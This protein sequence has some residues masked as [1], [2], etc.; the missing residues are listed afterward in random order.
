MKN[1]T[2]YLELTEDKV[3]PYAILSGDPRRVEKIITLLDDVVETSVSREYHTYRGTYKGM[4]VTVSSTGIGGPSAAI[5]LEELYEAGVE[6]AV[7]LGTVMGIGGNLGKFFVPVA[8]MR[9]ESTSKYYVDSSYPAVANNELVN[10]MNESILEHN[11]ESENGIVCST[12]GYY[13]GMKESRLSKEMDTDVI[14]F[15]EGLHKYNIKGLDM[16]TATLLTLGNLMNIKVCS[17][18]LATVTDNLNQ[19]I[20][21]EKRVE[22]ERILAQIVL[23][24]LLKLHKKENR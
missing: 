20:E 2:L 3:A 21:P 16:E 4:D 22:E 18:T 7:R 23:E 8:A 17:V 5:A 11:R 19:Y 24:G 14:G 9:H 13:T 1:Q 10:L 12:D 15:M 6:V